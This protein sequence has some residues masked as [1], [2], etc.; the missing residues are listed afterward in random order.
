MPHHVS[1]KHSRMSAV[2]RAAQFSPFA[3]LVGYDAAVQ[4]TGQLTTDKIELTEEEKSILDQRQKILM[5]RI[6]EH[7][8]VSV[9]YFLPDEKKSGGSYITATGHLKRIDDVE[10][11]IRLGDGTVISI[12]DIL[13]IDSEIFKEHMTDFC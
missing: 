13:K 6:V 5:E 11:V 7:P 10:H 4:E 12:D 3:A 9:T 8:E 2:D 1:S